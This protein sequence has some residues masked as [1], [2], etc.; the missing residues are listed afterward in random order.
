MS[1]QES[2]LISNR[3]SDHLCGLGHLSR[4]QDIETITGFV[5]P[6]LWDQFETQ[7]R[8]TASNR[9]L[10]DRRRE[11]YRRTG[12]FRSTFS[13]KQEQEFFDDLIDRLPD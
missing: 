9:R 8:R 6:P 12:E 7:A 10:A 11:S 5:V 3:R 1:A 2:M 4:R 13:A